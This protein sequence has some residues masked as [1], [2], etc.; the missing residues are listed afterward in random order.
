MKKKTHT[1]KLI[2]YGTG[3]AI[4]EFCG[5]RIVDLKLTLLLHSELWVKL[6]KL[7]SQRRMLSMLGGTLE[8][9]VRTMSR[10]LHISK[11]NFKNH[12]LHNK[13][14]TSPSST[15][16]AV[17]IESKIID[18]K[19]RRVWTVPMCVTTCKYHLV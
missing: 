14:R 3:Q 18:V 11:N 17:K 1:C 4:F 12:R 10:T 7:K 8:K 13:F 16:N 15:Q 19:E 9:H 2:V 6:I 5:I